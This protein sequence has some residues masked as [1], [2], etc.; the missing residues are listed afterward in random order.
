MKMFFKHDTIIFL[1]SLACA[2]GIQAATLVNGGLEDSEGSFI[3]GRDNISMQNTAPTGWA[4]GSQDAR[5]SSPDWIMEGTSA[6]GPGS[7]GFT[8]NGTQG[9]HFLGLDVFNDGGS[10]S[11][12][13]TVGDFTGGSYLITFDHSQFLGSAD[14]ANYSFDGKGGI[15]VLLDGVQAGSFATL[16]TSLLDWNSTGIM[17][18]S[19]WNTSSLLI[20][21]SAGSHVIEFEAYYI[22]GGLNLGGNVTEVSSQLIDNIQL[23]PVP[24][25]SGALLA[26]LGSGFL[27]IRRRR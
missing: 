3:I 9:T 24:E 5:M 13:Q 18:D 4:L 7:P 23:T 22:S 10:N 26:L 12:Q 2:T 11:I 27:Q 16:N 19:E 17:P 14:P 20:T 15:T 8:T 21:P 1:C 6:G 25:P